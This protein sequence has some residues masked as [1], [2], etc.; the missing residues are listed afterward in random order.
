MDEENCVKESGT[1]GATGPGSSPGGGST[2]PP[3]VDCDN[4]SHIVGCPGQPLEVVLVGDKTDRV[5]VEPI[6]DESTDTWHF[7]TFVNGVAQTPTVDSGI[8]CSEP[9]P[10]APK[11][12]EPV[13]ECRND[14]LWNVWYSVDPTGN[15][16]PVE[17]AAVDTGIPCTPEEACHVAT[18][19]RLSDPTG[20]L[21][22][23]E[24]DLG[25][26]VRDPFTGGALQSEA[27]GRSIRESFD[28]SAPTTVDGPWAGLNVNDTNNA[29]TVQ[30]AQVIEG[31]II[32]DTPTYVRWIGGTAGYNAMEVGECCGALSLV[33]EGAWTDGTSNP[34]NSTLLGVGV[35]SIRLWNIDDYS[36]TAKSL[37]YSPDG[38]NWTTDNTPPGVTLTRSK[39]TEECRH[40]KVCPDVATDLI[41]GDKV[42]LSD[43]WTACPKLCD[44]GSAATEQIPAPIGTVC[45]L[46]SEDEWDPTTSA[47][48]GTTGG[49]EVVTI[50]AATL[51]IEIEDNGAPVAAYGG[52]LGI[53]TGGYGP[54]L[55][56]SRCV[57]LTWDV[58]DGCV[59][60]Y[61]VAGNY[62][63][64]S[65]GAARLATRFE[66]CPT[67]YKIVGNQ[68]FEDGYLTPTQNTSVADGLIVDVVGSGSTLLTMSHTF[69]TLSRQ[70]I[71]DVAVRCYAEA[72]A[73]LSE[74]GA[75][76]YKDP[77]DPDRAILGADLRSCP[78]V[79]AQTVD[80]DKDCCSGDCCETLDFVVNESN[81]DNASWYNSPV[82]SA[83]P[84]DK[85]CYRIGEI[86][87]VGGNPGRAWVMVGLTTH[88]KSSYY[89]ALDY[90]A[91]T[92]APNPTTRYLYAYENNQSVGGL[93]TRL[94]PGQTVCVVRRGDVVQLEVDGETVF[95][96][97][98]LA[99]SK[100]MYA[101][102]AVLNSGARGAFT[103]EMSTCDLPDRCA[104]GDCCGSCDEWPQRRYA[105]A[106]GTNAWSNQGPYSTCPVKSTCW[107][108]GDKSDRIPM[109]FGLG[110][111]DPTA[112]ASYTTFRHRVYWYQTATGSVRLGVYD[113]NAF[114]GW[115]IGPQDIPAG[116]EICIRQLPDGHI[117]YTLD[118]VEF[119]RSAAAHPE[120]LWA[121]SSW[122]GQGSAYW[123]GGVEMRTENCR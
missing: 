118:G 105:T 20:D 38:V 36:A 113:D 111:T 114:Q 59:L 34:T 60:S 106:D 103:V 33:I 45:Y 13:E 35:H 119:Y 50:G 83:C 94:S 17:F 92:Y 77:A 64:E 2:P 54:D 115:L 37:Q 6:C 49:R 74:S 122:Y 70:T 15:T 8:R 10:A 104:D 80:C 73:L 44:P 61:K 71:R 25:P 63:I 84:T 46:K 82:T 32:V 78:N 42:D 1:I 66:P 31:F 56:S 62:L 117:S 3:G 5:D 86:T 96:Y 11:D 65:G 51:T 85:V 121:D 40:V 52:G 97:P 90:T 57:R 53:G 102:T 21:R 81:N 19:Y 4:P 69:N 55:Q 87:P 75:T 16:P 24:W 18:M 110:S 89:T 26:R 107:T 120:P 58:P 72:T 108:V 7:V 79:T 93:V 12:V 27:W 48:I 76:S 100:P 112:S 14:T 39:P 67:D 116:S 23:R 47:L 88:P 43:G 109:M 28:F 30:D 123:N 29:S 99:S 91:Y 101:S 41:T 95:T 9:P 98:T 68:R 22:N